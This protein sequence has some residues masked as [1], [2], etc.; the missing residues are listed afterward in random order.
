MHKE[1]KNRKGWI[2]YEK[3]GLKGGKGANR[4]TF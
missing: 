2:T 1:V 4:G 3:G